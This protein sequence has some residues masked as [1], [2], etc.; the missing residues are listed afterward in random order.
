MGIQ[1]NEISP[2]AKGGTE[3]MCRELEKRISPTLLDEFQ[4]IPSRLRG[5]LDE[6]KIRLYYA[7]DTESDPEAEKALG[8]GNHS[9]FHRIVFVS[10]HQMQRFIQ[11]FDLPWEKCVVIR[12]AIM[13]FEWND[14]PKGNIRLIYTSTPQRGLDVLGAA[15]AHLAERYDDIELEI[16]SSY[17]LYGWKDADAQFQPLFDKLDSTPRLTRHGTVSNAVIRQALTQAHIFAYPSTW[18]ETSCL[19]LMEAMAAGLVCVHPNYGALYETASNLTMMY[20]WTPDKQQH[21]GLFSVVLD[22]AI[23]AIREQ[24]EQ[25]AERLKTQSFNSSIFFGWN[26]REIE[27]KAFLESLLVLPRE[28]EKPM[29]V[30][31]V[32]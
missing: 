8:G 5:E 21:A 1:W 9:R 13:P 15:F 25:M 16:Y 26:S 32:S 19:C 11:H 30:Y 14:K 31:K 29:F 4:I 7:H 2:N 10:N 18:I 12:N 27:W 3:Q 22:Q 17:D 20:Q 23:R 24:P 6:S 28:F